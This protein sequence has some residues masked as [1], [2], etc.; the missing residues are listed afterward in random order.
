MCFIG[1]F[2]GCSSLQFFNKS[3]PKASKPLRKEFD[4]SVFLNE[5][6]TKSHNKDTT[7]ECRYFLKSI[8]LGVNRLSW[9]I[10]TRIAAQKR[11]KAQR[12][13]LQKG[14]IKNYSVII[15][16]KNFYGQPIDSVIKRIEE[17]RK[18]TTWQGEDYTTWCLL[19][20]DNIKNH[21]KWIAV[22]LSRQ[23]KSNIQKLIQNKFIK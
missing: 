19:D 4:R 11:C 17:I 22:D 18:L 1:C 5:Y 9:F 6:D 10:Q 14:V 20:N 21:Y 16:G 23:E 3:Q 13:Y 15:N 2:V 8:F 7:N 12:Y